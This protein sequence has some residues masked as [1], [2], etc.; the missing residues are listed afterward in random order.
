LLMKNSLYRSFTIL[1]ILFL[2]FVYACSNR[3]LSLSKVLS[4]A[5]GNKTYRKIEAEKFHAVLQEVLKEH[6][7]EL[8]HFD[9]INDFYQENG[10]EA[11][12][13]KRFIPKE[14]LE[15][16]S[17]ARDSAGAHGINPTRFHAAAY[18]QL[19]QQVMDRSAIQN[20][21]EAYRQVALLEITTADNL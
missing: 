2:T 19:L 6:R 15:A 20:L 10:Y 1:S 21:D 12:L 7:K 13:L 9:F 3:E 18:Q 16:L 5:S 8:N 11:V 4:K 17:L 14:G